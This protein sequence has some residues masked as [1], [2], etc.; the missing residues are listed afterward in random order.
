MPVTTKQTQQTATPVDDGFAKQLESMLGSV[1][2]SKEKQ[3][4]CVERR[5]EQGQVS[6]DEVMQQAND[7]ISLAQIVDMTLQQAGDLLAQLYYRIESASQDAGTNYVDLN[8]RIREQ[9]AALDDLF[10]SVTFQQQ[11]VFQQPGHRHFPT[12]VKQGE[13]LTLQIPNTSLSQLGA[14]SWQMVDG[15]VLPIRQQQQ[16]SYRFNNLRLQTGQRVRLMVGE[17]DVLQE[18]LHDLNSTMQTVADLINQVDLDWL[19]DAIVEQGVLNINATGVEQSQLTI[20]A[21]AVAVEDSLA[22]LQVASQEH[23]QASMQVIIG[24]INMLA[25]YRDVAV[26]VASELHQAM[27]NLMAMPRGEEINAPLAEAM[28]KDVQKMFAQQ[29]VKSVLAQ[30][31]L[32]D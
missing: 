8:N 1:G 29:P 6:V 18:C 5:V 27:N 13:Q 20:E 21:P 22:T 28:V 16:L 4:Q 25:D 31:N 17:A 23:T 3:P 11:A 2:M 19:N 24:A 10:A 15:P 30:A 9:M 7:G 12:G 32:E 26:F 14:K